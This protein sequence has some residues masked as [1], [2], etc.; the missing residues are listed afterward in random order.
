MNR[1]WLIGLGIVAGCIA[2]WFYFTVIRHHLTLTTIKLYRDWFLTYAHAHPV[3]SRALYASAYFALVSCFFPAGAILNL[4]GGF[5]FGSIEGVIYANIAA[6]LGSILNFFIVRYII[7]EPLHKKYAVALK[8]FNAAFKKNGVN[9]LLSVRLMAIFPF[10]F[11]NTLIGLTN[12]PLKTYIWT[13]MLGILPGQALFVFM[14]KQ[15]GTI[16]SIGQILTP[17]V[18]TVFFAL[19]GCALLPTLLKKKKSKEETSIKAI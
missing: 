6:T 9:Y 13:T 3:K 8:S 17:Q 15:L 2:L 14:G 7:A 18:W 16:T 1:K 19:A 12:V 11:S 10:P 5:L 4:L